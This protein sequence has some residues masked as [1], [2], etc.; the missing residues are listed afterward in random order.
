MNKL[1]A[2][3]SLAH[4]ILVKHAAVKGMSGTKGMLERF[5]KQKINAYDSL[6][7]QQA[8]EIDEYFKRFAYDID[9]TGRF[10]SG[11]IYQVRSSVGSGSFMFKSEAF[12]DGASLK[13]VDP[14]DIFIDEKHKW[15]KEKIA[16]LSVGDRYDNFIKT[17]VNDS[18][19]LPTAKQKVNTVKE[20]FLAH[21][22][23]GITIA[24]KFN[25]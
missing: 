3:L 1:G 14:G 15:D 16:G 21:I 7:D 20:K 23:N 5:A 12:P 10:I 4:I 19:S 11:W 6:T 13:S 9:K 17:I 25:L 22:Y 2:M 8:K 24:Q 18:R